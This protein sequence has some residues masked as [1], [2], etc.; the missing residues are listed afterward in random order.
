LRREWSWCSSE[1][2]ARS[3]GV[4]FSPEAPPDSPSPWIVIV[5]RLADDLGWVVARVVGRVVGRVVAALS[6]VVGVVS[7][8]WTNCPVA[9][10]PCP[11]APRADPGHFTTGSIHCCWAAAPGAPRS[12]GL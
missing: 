4:S 10:P 11:E 12:T 6:L 2:D 3:A 9:S 8:G 5:L 7:F 1:I